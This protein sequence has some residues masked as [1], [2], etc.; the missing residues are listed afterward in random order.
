MT[1]TSQVKGHNT[2]K[3]YSEVDQAAYIRC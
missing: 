1:A 3:I 2:V